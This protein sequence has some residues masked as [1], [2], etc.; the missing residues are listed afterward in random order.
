MDSLFQGN[1]KEIRVYRVLISVEENNKSKD[2]GAVEDE[3]YKTLLC[4]SGCFGFL[5]SKKN[6][7][8]FE[9]FG[10]PFSFGLQFLEIV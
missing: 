7:S 8:F 3:D 9:C 2:F 6:I 4:F 1:D 5:S 10:R